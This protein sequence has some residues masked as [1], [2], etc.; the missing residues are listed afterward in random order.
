MTAQLKNQDPS[1]PRRQHADGRADGAIL[2]RRRH[3]GDEHDA[4]GDLGQAGGYRAPTDT[5][6]LCGQDGPDRGRHR[7]CAGPA[8]GSR[9]RWNSAAMTSGR[10]RLDLGRQRF[11]VLKHASRWARKRRA[12]RSYDWDG[13][14]DR[15]ATKPVPGR[16]PSTSSPRRT[17][18]SRSR[19]A[20]RTWSGHPSSPSRCP[21]LRCAPQPDAARASARFPS[22]AVRQ[23][24]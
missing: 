5:L 8:A 20:R 17:P 1:Q 7:L 24:G 14:T 2:Q 23:I 10:E 11:K 22:T 12:P 4:E 21:R 19:H 9:A 3:L 6:S 18:T 16:S 13:K 15:G